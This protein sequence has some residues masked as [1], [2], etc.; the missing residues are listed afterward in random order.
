M[1]YRAF[2]GCLLI[3]ILFLCGCSNEGETSSSSSSSSAGNIDEMF[4]DMDFE[5]GY[6]ESTSMIVQLQGNTAAC[7]DST[8][9]VQENL[10]TISQGGTYILTGNFDNG[11]I[12]VDLV[13][14][15]DVHLVLENAVIHND[16]NAALYIRSANHVYLTFASGSENT[17]SN[18]G[19]YESIDDN[20]IDAALF[21]KSD[22]TL[23]G[24]GN[25][26]ITAQAGHGVVSK[27]DLIVTGGTY[28]VDAASQGLSGKDSV[29]IAD[30]S[31]TITSGKDG[32]HSENTEDASKGFVYV[33]DGT[34]TITAQGDGMS[35]SGYLQVQDGTFT[36]ETGG[37]SSSVTLQQGED[38]SNMSPSFGGFSTTQD[39]TQEDTTSMK[40]IK[41]DGDLILNGGTFSID[42]Q[43]DAL[44]TN[45][46]LTMGGGTYE[47]S[48]GDD[49]LHA[50]SNVTIQAGTIQ[51]T[52]SYEG[53][54]G[55]SIDIVEG[56]ITLVAS[57]DGLNA[58]GG[59]DE[60]GM[61]GF[62]P[63]SFAADSDAYILIRGGN[64]T[65]DAG[66]D[67]IDSNGSLTISGGQIFV[68]GPA[69]G[70]DGAL[71]YNGDAQITGGVF[72]ATGTSQMAQN[73]GSSSTQGSALV[74]V[75]T[76][77]AGTAICLTDASGQELVTWTA[78]K[79]FDSVLISCPEMTQGETY[80]LTVGSSETQI[81]L[82]S[83]VFNSGNAGGSFGNPGGGMGV[84]PGDMGGGPNGDS[85]RPGNQPW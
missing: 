4:T 53:I 72:V 15:E 57:D 44:H 12:L 60:S 29:R 36:L 22:L 77:Q 63:D 16:T 41:A 65:I 58:A 35:A 17:L 14:D 43:D 71:D 73:F 46:N 38:F 78:T 45:S 64:I 11:M 39:T 79:S 28:V 85:G 83:L 75:S 1:K 47:I 26:T 76:Q 32:I 61:A 84:T 82:D 59:T 7:D 25:L 19:T 9:Q 49:G 34:F 48:T 10:V 33:A 70:A 56:D 68:S 81:T 20:N 51:I 74:Q 55:Q 31:F 62:S 24:E 21:S 5:I 30:G 2:L 67:G 66:G 37:T 42:P 52:K 69:S 8:V 40:G 3:G 54:E 80:T 18:G 23:N 27:D 13:N 50:D 6:D